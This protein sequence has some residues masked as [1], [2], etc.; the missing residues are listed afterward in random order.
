MKSLIALFTTALALGQAVYASTA[1][2]DNNSR[3]PTQPGSHGD[4]RTGESVLVVRDF[5]PWGGDVVPLF[6]AANTVVTEIPTT[7]LASTDLSAFCMVFVTAG[8]LEP[9][10]LSSIRLNNARNRFTAYVEAGGT[11]LYQTGTWGAVMRLPGGVLTSLQYESMNHF[12]GFNLLSGGMPFPDFYCDFASHDVL[13]GLPEDAEVLI[14]TPGGLPTAAH[15]VLGAGDVLA[16]TQPLEAFLPGG[17]GYGNFAY[18][19]TLE[20][21][22]IAYARYLG[23]CGDIVIAAQDEPADFVLH[24]NYPNPFNPSTTV[25]FNLPETAFVQ[26]EVF[27]TVGRLVA[28]LADGLMERGEHAVRFNGD[29]L[30]SGLYFCRM[31]ALGQV[32]TSRMLL[33]K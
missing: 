32:R 9:F 17:S 27:D 14:T 10:S 19:E 22:A 5:L 16:L 33:V 25:S 8:T 11:L 12:T 28:T 4:L 6:L 21:N 2:A 24:D 31:S 30:S 7:A 20:E 13:T 15:Y 23:N 1:D 29:V 18:M 3:L 26:L